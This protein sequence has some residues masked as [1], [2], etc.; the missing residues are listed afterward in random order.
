MVKVYRYLE[1]LSL[2]FVWVM[3]EVNPVFWF[4]FVFCVTLMRAAATDTLV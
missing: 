2:N 1:H 4:L 3:D